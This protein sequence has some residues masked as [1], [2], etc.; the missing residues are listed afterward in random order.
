MS[1]QR[2]CVKHGVRRA[3]H[4][5]RACGPRP[6][7]YICTPGFSCVAKTIICKKP[8]AH[9]GNAMLM[10][11]DTFA[12]LS[13]AQKTVSPQRICVKHGVRRAMHDLR[14]CG[15][16]PCKYICTPGFSCVAKTI[17]CKKPAAHVGNAMLMQSDTFAALSAA[18]KTEKDSS[19]LSLPT[20]RW[21]RE[22]LQPNVKRFRIGCKSAI[23]M[24]WE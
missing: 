23:S 16:R 24:P 19:S 2:I 18:Q 10:Q 22:V 4:D 21:K 17:I 1:P 9:V 7:K 11:S 20:K 15:P 13:A 14:A 6:C 5:L 12:A 8:A 3:M